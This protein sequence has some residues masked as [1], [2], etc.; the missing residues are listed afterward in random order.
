MNLRAA[1]A[2]LAVLAVLAGCTDKPTGI[3]AGPPP[4][5]GAVLGLVAASATEPGWE[6]IIPAF[7][8]TEQ[9]RDVTVR[10][11]YGPSGEQAD[12]VADGKRADIVSLATEAEVAR[13]VDAGKVPREWNADVT[14]GIP[15]G[16]V[17]TL[18]VREGNPK[19]ITDWDDLLRPGVEV[20]TPS[21]LGPEPGT[22][23]LLAPYA[24]ASGGGRDQ[25]AGL[26]YLTRLVSGHVKVR[27]GSAAEAAEM[28]LAGTGD[29]L[30]SWES[31]A[32]GL[33]RRDPGGPT[34]EYVIPP[35]TIKVESPVAV[36]AATTQLDAAT[37]LRNFLFTEQGQRILAKAGLRPV[38]PAVA[39]EFAAEFPVP[40]TLW[41]I[42]DLG[43]WGSVEPALFARA[44][45]AGG[46]DGAITTI[47][48][49]EG[50]P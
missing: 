1:G 20:V 31:E 24:A 27:P 3:G 12:A 42:G 37:A 44:D 6:A 18:V 43:G 13:L 33:Q 47:Y 11:S 4:P 32:I 14:R 5:K 35:Q 48:R 26:D 49:N 22:W 46:A 7:A 16:S 29:V 15:F 38:D 30:I 41:T 36:P 34:V 40:R 21:P 25:R 10:A 17:V 45:G 28:F 8:A 2:V 39:A 23:N 19:D 9:G 50:R